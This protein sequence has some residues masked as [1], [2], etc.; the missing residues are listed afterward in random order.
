MS[1]QLTKLA[2]IAL[3]LSAVTLL[4]L[5]PVRATADSR[6]QEVLDLVAAHEA[7]AMKIRPLQDRVLVKFKPD[8]TPVRA[9]VSATPDASNNGAATRAPERLRHKDRAVSDSDEYGRIKVRFSAFEKKAK[10]ERERVNRPRFGADLT[11]SRSE[12]AGARKA[13]AALQRE[14]AT[15]EREVTALKR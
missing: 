6:S 3:G 15:L 10:A 13:L 8:G 9:K 5:L 12:I 4:G 2:V 14:F 11:R 1:T 7:L